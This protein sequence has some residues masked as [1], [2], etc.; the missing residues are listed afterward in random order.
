[1]LNIINEESAI[2]LI[3][4]GDLHLGH[5]AC[6]LEKIRKTIKKIRETKNARVILMGDIID[7]GL[8]NSIGG[9]TYDNDFPPQEQFDLAVELL[10]PIKDKIYG[11][12]SG[13]HSNRIFNATSLEIDKLLGQRLG[14]KWLGSSAY[15][16]IKIGKKNFVI[17]STHGSSGASLPHTKIKAVMDLANFHECDIYMYGHNHE[18]AYTIDEKFYV[19]MRS[20]TI[21]RKQRHFILTGHYLNYEGY[22]AM[23]SY[24]PSRLGSPL[25]KLSEDKPIE[26]LFL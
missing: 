4:L 3:A 22:V 14:V 19:D 18:L 15:H 16:K 13:N 25:I 10:Q 26:V 12:H 23:K 5:K 2:S 1:M 6:N 17:Y 8:R 20:S 24:K 21:K 7:A 11:I 9:G